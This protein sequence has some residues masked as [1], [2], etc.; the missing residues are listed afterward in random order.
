MS[1]DEVFCRGKLSLASGKKA[2]S[3]TVGDEEKAGKQQ[4]SDHGN[5]ESFG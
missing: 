5:L 4:V 3:E 1:P 2:E